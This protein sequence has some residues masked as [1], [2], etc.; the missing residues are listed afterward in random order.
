MQDWQAQF[1]AMRVAFLSRASA[2]LDKISNLLERL[3]NTPTDAEIL[4]EVRQ[5]FH[6]LCGVGGTY[7]IPKVS[8]LGWEGEELCDRLVDNG[9]TPTVSDV[10]RLQDL[11][12]SVRNQ[13]LSVELN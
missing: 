1:Q 11:L 13:F 3:K 8:D 2:R 7:K 12:G 6:W 5:D 4:A 10:M 9:E